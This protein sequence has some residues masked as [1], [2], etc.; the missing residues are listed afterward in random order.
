MPWSSFFFRLGGSYTALG[1]ACGNIRVTRTSV[2]RTLEPQR[3]WL[4]LSL[5]LQLVSVGQH[6]LVVRVES[7]GLG[8]PLALGLRQLLLLIGVDVR[9]GKGAL[10]S[11]LVLGLRLL[12]STHR[13]GCSRGYCS[14]LYWHTLRVR[15]PGGRG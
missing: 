3:V 2:G 11:Q 9:M 15:G 5:G 6:G 14:W 13:R 10:R 7:E 12:L 1:N 8:A 4:L